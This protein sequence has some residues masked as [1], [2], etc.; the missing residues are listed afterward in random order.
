MERETF[1]E[2]LAQAIRD[3][4]PAEVN[5]KSWFGARSVDLDISEPMLRAYAKEENECAASTLL[6][7]FELWGSKF[8]AKVRGTPPSH[9]SQAMA[10]IEAFE[11]V[12]ADARKGLDGETRIV[13]IAG[14]IG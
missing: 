14:K 8:E 11:E 4:I 10:V 1:L 9:D 3:E 7:M 6:R 2:R 5:R 13:P 12:C